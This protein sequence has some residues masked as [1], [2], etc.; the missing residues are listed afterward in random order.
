MCSKESWSILL[1]R[2]DEVVCPS[3]TMP[4]MRSSAPTTTALVSR[5]SSPWCSCVRSASFVSVDATTAPR[6]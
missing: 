3:S 4:H 1:A 2:V 5:A 6:K